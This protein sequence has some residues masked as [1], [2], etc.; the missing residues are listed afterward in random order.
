[1]TLFPIMIVPTFFG[2]FFFAWHGTATFISALNV[3]HDES[4]DEVTN[5][6]NDI[7]IA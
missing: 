5:L 2:S 3:R 1:M 4:H 6:Y 7:S